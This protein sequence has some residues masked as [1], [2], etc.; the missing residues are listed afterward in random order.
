MLVILDSIKPASPS[1]VENWV[2][3]AAVVLH[4]FRQAEHPG[5]ELNVYIGELR[6]KEERSLGI[7]GVDDF[8]DLIF[9][10]GG[11]FCLFAELLGL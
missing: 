7:Q 10:L 1:A 11:I 3:P 2:R 6:T 9:E 5:C 8:C 4:Y